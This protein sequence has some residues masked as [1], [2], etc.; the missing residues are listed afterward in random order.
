MPIL[1]LGNLGA[2]FLVESPEATTPFVAQASQGKLLSSSILL[3]PSGFR[4][5]VSLPLWSTSFVGTLGDTPSTNPMG[6]KMDT[7]ICKDGFMAKRFLWTNQRNQV[8]LTRNHLTEYEAV[9]KAARNSFD[10][11]QRGLCTCFIKFTK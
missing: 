11:Q 1:V 6:N 4:E 2:H 10:P 8:F 5:F 7:V 9:L 3:T